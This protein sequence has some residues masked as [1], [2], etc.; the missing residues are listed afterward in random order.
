[1]SSPGNYARKVALHTFTH[2]RMLQASTA[3]GRAA[4][5]D[6]TVRKMYRL[7]AGWGGVADNTPFSKDSILRNP[8]N[9]EAW[10]GLSVPPTSGT[11]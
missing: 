9:T 6:L 2:V 5:S 10:T 1:M 4:T 7:R 8:E 11:H 3:A